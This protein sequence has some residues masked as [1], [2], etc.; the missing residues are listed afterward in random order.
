MQLTELHLKAFGPF[1]DQ[2]LPLGAG[3]QQLVLVYGLNEAGKSSALRAIA[4]LRFGI[5]TR[6]K[7]RFV[8]DYAQMRVGGVFVDAQGQ[9]YS[10]MRRKGTGVTLKFADF[11]RGGVELP[12]PVPAA[13]YQLLTGGLP[14]DD[15]K[16]MFG[17]DHAALRAGGA[18][19]ARGEGEIGAALF[20]ASAGAADVQ[21]MLA[22]LDASAKK[23]FMPAANAKNA[24]I[25]QALADYKSHHEHYKKAQVKPARWEAVDNAQKQARAALDD[26]RQALQNHQNGLSLSRELIAV[27][28]ILAALDHASALAQTLSTQPLLAESAAS[29]R[30]AAEAGGFEAVADAARHCASVA[31]LR[32]ALAQL[33]LDPAIL[34][35][36]QSVTRL[37]ASAGAVSQLHGQVALARSDR[38]HVS[39]TLDSLAARMDPTASVGALLKSAPNLTVTAHT[40]TC[41]DA[42]AHS[43]RALMQHQQAAPAAAAGDSLC[44]APVLDAAAQTGLRLALAELAESASLLQALAKLP[45]A[46][47]L[48]QRFASQKLLDTGLVDEAA[49]RRVSPLLAAEI[50]NA[51]EQTTALVSERAEKVKRIEDMQLSMACLQR[52]MGELLAQGMVPTHAE[53]R[54]A[55]AARQNGWTLVRAT[56]IDRSA[57][58]AAAVAEWTEGRPL[59]ETYEKSVAQ[60]DVLMD[61][62]AS[63]TG[64]VTQLEAARRRQADLQNDLQLRQS[65]IAGI[66]ARQTALQ[67]R[68]TQTLAAAHIPHMLPAALRDWQTRLAAVLA[69]FDGLLAQHDELALARLV[70]NRL[71]DT[72]RQA[73]ARLVPDAPGL[74]DAPLASLKVMSEDAQVQIQQQLQVQSKA[75]GEALQLQKQAQQHASK[76]RELTWDAEKAQGDFSACLARLMLPGDA[77]AAVAKARL[78]EFETLLA[79]SRALIQAQAN[80]E[81]HTASLLGFQAMARSIASALDETEPGDLLVA[82]EKWDNRLTH[83]QAQQAQSLLAAQQL[84][85]AESALLAS[86][87]RALQHQG[88]LAR[89]CAAAGVLSESELPEAEYKSARK[90]QAL[91]DA[92]AAAA[93]LAKASRR[94][95][96]ALQTLLAGRTHETLQ[97]DEIHRSEL[98]NQAAELLE[99]ARTVDETARAELAALDA[100]GSAAASFEAMASAVATVKNTLPLYARSRLAHALLHEAI[101]RFKE[102]SQAPMLKSASSYFAQITGGEF[103][104]LVNDDSQERPV[105][106]ARRPHASGGALVQVDA[107]S[108]GTADQLYLA[109]RLAALDLQRQRGVDLPVIL[110]DV[111]MTSDDAR[112]VCI[113][114][115]LQRFSKTGQVI[116]FTHHHHLCDLARNCLPPETLAV[117][118]LRRE[119]A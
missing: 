101:E 17:L 92:D 42:L 107:M 52:E 115:A 102:R 81:R 119:A 53:V 69:A 25:N 57:A 32:E 105:I 26:A 47:K 20:E 118:E 70:E 84:K 66:E 87:N 48:A 27:A 113:F 7:D 116:V 50:D 55:R 83:A 111:L 4:G 67:Q 58:D 85:S 1:T 98:V 100:A 72:L 36:A 15:Y 43:S 103:E 86:Q 22:E 38:T 16:T 90:R 62:L 91:R 77:S 46:I 18:A 41:M 23:F 82:S 74:L 24:R 30:A 44:L 28:P 89:L 33:T 95:I 45:A 11:A 56:Y 75:A 12:E 14:A 117:V 108:E 99:K 73:L 29:E 78:D 61:S 19:L 88:S 65:E 2:V 31:A 6:S 79:A 40:Q 109:L 68:W 106:A 51:L 114:Q 3:T 10:L 63:D 39:Q 59:P 64:R 97:A 76:Q 21:K 37:Q 5:D 34:A 80:W 110:D 112:A 13:V 49:A 96:V 60:A 71:T 8:H 93:Q 104:G 94:D 35:I 9:S 54:Q